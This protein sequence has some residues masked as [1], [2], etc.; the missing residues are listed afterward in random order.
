M[1]RMAAAITLALLLSGC[2]LLYMTA[3]WCARH[4]DASD[5]HCPEHGK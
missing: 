5:L 1:M 3:D 2:G 4:P